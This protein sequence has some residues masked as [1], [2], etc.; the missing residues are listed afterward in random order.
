MRYDHA[1]LA[2]F[3][4]SFSK[5][6]EIIGKSDIGLY[7]LTSLAVFPSLC[8]IIIS[9]TRHMLQPDYCMSTLLLLFWTGFLVIHR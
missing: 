9:A 1:F 3:K 5:S 4:S 6:L 2:I 8:S 7:D